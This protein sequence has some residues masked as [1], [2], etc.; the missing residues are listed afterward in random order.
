MQW[1]SKKCYKCRT[2]Q[3]QFD[4]LNEDRSKAYYMARKKRRNRSLHE[5]S[6]SKPSAHQQY[7]PAGEKTNEEIEQL[8]QEQRN[9]ANKERED[10]KAKYGAYPDEVV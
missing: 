7:E 8:K 4:T 9:I 5:I 3:M 6:K 10:F 1:I 2:S